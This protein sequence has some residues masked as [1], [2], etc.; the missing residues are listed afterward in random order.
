MKPIRKN[1]L[2]DHHDTNRFIMSNFTHE[3]QE[4]VFDKVDKPCYTTIWRNVRDETTF[5]FEEMFWDRL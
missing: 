5:E 4:K 3:D 1:L 2:M